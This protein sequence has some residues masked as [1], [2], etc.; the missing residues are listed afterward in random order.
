M[1]C[2]VV[3]NIE[4]HSSKGTFWRSFKAMGVVGSAECGGNPYIKDLNVKI[5]VNDDSEYRYYGVC[6]P[7]HTEAVLSVFDKCDLVI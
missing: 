1:L 4:L 3:Q 6:K 5:M 2:I 7:D